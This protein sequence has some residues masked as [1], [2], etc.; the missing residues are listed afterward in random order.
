MSWL[1]EFYVLMSEQ[2]CIQS[3]KVP[4][5]KSCCNI[6]LILSVQANKRETFIE[7]HV[8]REIKVFWSHRHTQH[9]KQCY[10][11]LMVQTTEPLS[12]V[13][14]PFK[15]QNLAAVQILSFHA[16]FSLTHSPFPSLSV[17][18]CQPW[19]QPA[20]L[21]GP[22]LQAAINRPSTTFQTCLNVQ[23]L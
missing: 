8:K 10:A 16:N 14:S 9:R 3:H 7:L 19:R 17:S 6:A 22:M 4:T 21:S 13:G 11:V 20:C 18:L 1:E 2:I 5:G 12:A 23:S 15:Q